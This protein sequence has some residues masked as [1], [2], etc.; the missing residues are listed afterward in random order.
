M[1]AILVGTHLHNH[2]W[3]LTGR[4]GCCSLIPTSFCGCSD[5]LAVLCLQASA[6]TLPRPLFVEC[7]APGRTSTYPFGV[8]KLQY[9]K[10]SNCPYLLIRRE[11]LDPTVSREARQAFEIALGE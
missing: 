7:V 10:P 11:I 3:Y 9:H 5:L 4:A 6:T 2:L 8:I 1:A